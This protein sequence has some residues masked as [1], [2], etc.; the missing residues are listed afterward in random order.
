MSCDTLVTPRPV[1]LRT[2]VPTESP[3]RCN[4]VIV[5]GADNAHTTREAAVEILALRAFNAADRD[6]V[7]VTRK[8][9]DKL[10]AELARHS[11]TCGCGL[12]CLLPLAAPSRVYWTASVWQRSINYTRAR[13]TR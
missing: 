2:G 13:A 5:A 1:G 6:G 8:L 11:D 9:T 10:L 4:D 3:I 7:V 12:C